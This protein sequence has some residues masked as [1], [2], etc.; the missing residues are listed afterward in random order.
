MKKVLL[1]DDDPTMLL[2][3]S[4]V[5]KDNF[6]VITQEGGDDA[7]AWL[8]EGN[9]PNLIVCDIQM[10]DVT[11]MEVLEYVKESSFY[12]EIP[13]IMLSAKKKSADR[14]LC[15]KK[16]ADDYLVKPFNPEELEIRIT[17]LLR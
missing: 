6:E 7:L 8:G 5:L 1:I 14:I 13:V 15:L 3:V 2:L 16:G 9:M 10:P 12:K 17:K 11:G 4:T